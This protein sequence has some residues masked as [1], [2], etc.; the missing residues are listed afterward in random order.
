LS[1]TLLP[2]IVQMESIKIL[3]KNKDAN[4]ITVQAYNRIAPE[5]CRRTRQ[6]KYLQWEEKYITKMLELVA[7]NNP[8]I[9]DVGCGDGRHCMIIEKYN[10]R[11][12]GIDLSKSMIKECNKLYSKG[13]FRVMDMRA[14]NFKDDYFDGIWASGSIYH[15]PKSEVIYIIKEF[16]RVINNSGVKKYTVTK[17]NRCG[18]DW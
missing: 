15:V 16:K 14:L 1:T 9:L 12:I 2:Q 7:K 6:K 11:A 17:L 10:G 13:D 18:L 5:Y 4:K 8:L 3:P